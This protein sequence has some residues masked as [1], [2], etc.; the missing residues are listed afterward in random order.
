[1]ALREV[2]AI[3]LSRPARFAH[4]ASRLFD[5]PTLIVAMFCVSGASAV[6]AASGVP[7][8]L[9]LGAEFDDLSR[10]HAKKRG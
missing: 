4:L 9:D 3:A 6:D 2:V 7:L 10:R 1:M 5:N 8:N